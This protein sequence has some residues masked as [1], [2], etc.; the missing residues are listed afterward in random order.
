MKKF[1]CIFLL[2]TMIFCSGYRKP[3]KYVINAEKD[4]FFHNDNGLLYLREKTYYAAL[5]E[6]KIAI[7]LSPNTQSTAI[8]KTNMGKTY[9][10]MGYPELA[11]QPLEEAI[12]AYGLNF[13]Y[14]LNLA[15]CYEKLG[16]IPQKIAEYE[17]S[18]YVYDKIILGILY[19]KTN[20]ITRGIIT[21]DDF[22]YSEPDLLITPAIKQYIKDL[23]R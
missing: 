17:N 18:A 1:L 12:K 2:L 15:D 16:I 10:I 5:Q 9:M 22:C 3:Y 23:K 20:N 8:F 7:S 4:A 13:Q 14:Y 21:L 19:I 11:K 6:F